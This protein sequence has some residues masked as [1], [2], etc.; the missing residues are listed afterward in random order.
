MMHGLAKFK[1]ILFF[2]LYF[3]KNKYYFRF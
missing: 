3:E 2:L 1:L